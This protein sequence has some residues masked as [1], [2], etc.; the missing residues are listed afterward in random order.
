MNVTNWNSN[1]QDWVENRKH[2][3][4]LKENGSHW[5]GIKKKKGFA[6][7][8]IKGESDKTLIFSFVY[9]QGLDY[10]DHSDPFLVFEK[11]GNL[12]GLLISD[13]DFYKNDLPPIITK[14]KKQY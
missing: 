10:L 6:K 13:C 1:V 4:V 8:Y 11:E 9:F 7:K 5:I 14:I 12:T 3:A 2:I